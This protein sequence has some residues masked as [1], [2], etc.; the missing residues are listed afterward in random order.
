MTIFYFIFLLLLLVYMGFCRNLHVK[1]TG[2]KYMDS[3]R[4]FVKILK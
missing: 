4:W 3:Y 2:N 1:R